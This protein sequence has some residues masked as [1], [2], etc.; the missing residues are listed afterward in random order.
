MKEIRM[1]VSK[2][3]PWDISVGS[4]ATPS[5]AF[6]NGMQNNML[7]DYWGNLTI[8]VTYYPTSDRNAQT[9]FETMAP[10]EILERLVKVP[11]HTWSYKSEDG[12]CRLGPVSQDFHAAFGL[13]A[14]D[15]HIATVDAAGVALAAI[16]GLNQKLT[17]ELKLRDAENAAMR[18]EL[19]ELRQLANSLIP[20]PSGDGQ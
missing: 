20:T 11:I 16:Q 3:T 17:E 12:V 5:L 19:A 8:T 18:R 1:G 15:K 4:G 7:L 2:G 9:G 6:Y 13:G 10:R 14:D